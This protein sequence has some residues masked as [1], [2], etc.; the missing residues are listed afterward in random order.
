MP[1]PPTAAAPFVLAPEVAA[2][3]AAGRPIVALESTVIAHGLPWPTNL[4]T[5]QAC[6]AAVRDAGAVPATMAVFGGVVHVG[7]DAA[8]LERLARGTGVAKLS[9]RDLPLALTTGAD[10]ATTVAAT[11][12]LA[13]AAPA[14]IRVFATGGIGGV[15]RG[16]A[17]TLDISADLPVL[18]RASCVTVCAGAKL[19]LDL[20]ATREWLETHGVPVLGWQ[21]DQFPAFY[22]RE[23]GLRADARVED[24][25]QVAA[26]VRARQA[27][28][29]PA[30][31]LVVAPIPEVAA[32]PAAEIAGAVA[33]ALAAAAAQGIGGKD[34]TPFL[35]GR[36]HERTAGRSLQA[37]IALLLNNAAIAGRIAVAL[38]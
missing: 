14:T 15:H 33:E 28:G 1:D 6:E 23:S 19:I 18:A 31:A 35:L 11:L 20:P 2:A 21:T 29:L 12:H 5:A 24:A 27:L 9:I 8:Q 38:A 16:W 3:A 13:Q 26:V 25:A 37:N 32:I 34:L 30:G 7:C 4:E 36:L 22:T 10:G 17:Q